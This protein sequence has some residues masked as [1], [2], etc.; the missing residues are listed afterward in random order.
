MVHEKYKRSFMIRIGKRNLIAPNKDDP[1]NISLKV[2][3]QVNKLLLLPSKNSGHKTVIRGIIRF[4]L[5]KMHDHKAPLV[6]RRQPF[7]L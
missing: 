5:K 7:S 3:Y 6:A 1:Q 4:Q 2:C